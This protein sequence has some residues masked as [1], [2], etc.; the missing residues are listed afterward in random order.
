LPDALRTAAAVVLA[1]PV[2]ASIYLAALVRARPRVGS[3]AAATLAIPVVASIYLSAVA[4]ARSGRA[5]L[6]VVAA[7]VGVI[8]F[9]ALDLPAG[10]GAQPPS[11]VAPLPDGDFR[12]VTLAGS[13]PA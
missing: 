1:I 11:E 7:I 6:I 10:I 9:T 5:A 13:Q 12:A 4:R 2:I 3:I 8:G